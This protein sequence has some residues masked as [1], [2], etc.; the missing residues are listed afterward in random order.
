MQRIQ[1]FSIAILVALFSVCLL[2]PLSTEAV[3]PKTEHILLKIRQAAKR[4]QVI[5]SSFSLNSHKHHLIKR[6]GKPDPFPKSTFT[7]L[8]FTKRDLAFHFNNQSRI[9]QITS[10]D[11]QLLNINVQQM[12]RI[13]GKPNLTES[14]A[15]HRYFSYYLGTYELVFVWDNAR[16]KFEQVIVQPKIN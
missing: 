11:P 8:Q 10:T 2:S 3:S 1:L 4:G 13:L 16:K 14:A 9:D 15:G 5:N 7:Y 12:R 6:Y